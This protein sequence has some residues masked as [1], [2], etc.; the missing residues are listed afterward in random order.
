MKQHKYLVISAISRRSLH[1]QWITDDRNFDV[2][3]INYESDL[4]DSIEHEEGVEEHFHKGSKFELTKWYIETFGNHYDAYLLLD[5]DILTNA[6]DINKM[7]EYM[8]E[9]DLHIAHPALN[10]INVTSPNLCPA[11][12]TI[13][14]YTNWIELQAVLM[15]KEVMY[16]IVDYLAES[17]SGWG[18]PELWLKLCNQPFGVIDKVTVTHTRPQFAGE[19]SIY[20]L[21]GGIQGAYKEYLHLLKRYNLPTPDES[22][23]KVISYIPDKPL[24]SI[25]CIYN[26]DDMKYIP[27]MLESISVLSDYCEVVLVETI[28]DFNIDDPTMRILKQTNLRQKAVWHYSPSIVNF[29]GEELEIFDFA[30]A[31]NA[32]LNLARGEWVL[33]VDADERLIPTQAKHLLESLA[34]TPEDVGGFYTT[35]YNFIPWSEGEE[36]YK[37]R[38]LATACR[39]FRNREDIEWEYPVHEKVENTI[40]AAGFKM[41]ELSLLI[42]HVGQ[43]ISAEEKLIKIKKYIATIWAHPW[44]METNRYTNY[45]INSTVLYK[46]LK[47]LTNG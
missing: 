17:K 46:Q 4:Q 43:A 21:T 35:Q 44:L 45:L 15:T 25:V 11:K 47:E 5:D 10:P 42:D 18:F 9:Y 41:A 27:E 30:E 14:R 40:K 39:L 31:R 2:V 3:L 32:A 24:L 28:A 22:P 7:F 13:I 16:N 19:N 26:R 34:E 37:T 29:D 12:N 23:F 36:G 38:M 33:S 8:A 1:L 20:K 6:H